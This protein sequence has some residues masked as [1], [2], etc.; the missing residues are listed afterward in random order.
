MAATNDP[1]YKTFCGE[2]THF[3]DGEKYL[4][5][6]YSNWTKEHC[7]SGG[8]NINT[9]KSRLGKSLFCQPHHLLPVKS[10]IERSLEL[11]KEQGYNKEARERSLTRSRLESSDEV[12]SQKWLCK[13][14]C[15][16]NARIGF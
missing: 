3:K 13:K 2:H 15:K 12:L 9:I 6:D 7:E 10:Y 8:V 1:T 5:A 14:L 11:R 4:Y 16:K